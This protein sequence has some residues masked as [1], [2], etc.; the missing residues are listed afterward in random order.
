MIGTEDHSQRPIVDF[1]VCAGRRQPLA[2]RRE[3]AAVWLHA[4]RRVPSEGKTGRDEEHDDERGPQKRAESIS[5]PH[6]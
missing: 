4:D 1:D 6:H 2:D 5:D 3:N